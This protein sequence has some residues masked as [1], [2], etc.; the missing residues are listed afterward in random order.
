ML[1]VADVAARR[2][3]A[4]S[5]CLLMTQ[6]LKPG[7]DSDQVSASLHECQRARATYAAIDCGTNYIVLERNFQSIKSGKNTQL[8][9]Y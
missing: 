3:T 9:M 8:L 5:S 2:H 6:L 7:A 4:H 1:S